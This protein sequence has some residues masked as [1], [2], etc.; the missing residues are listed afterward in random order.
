MW[1]LK[2][3]PYVWT[4]GH[5]QENN[6]RVKNWRYYFDKEINEMRVFFFWILWYKYHVCNKEK[7]NQHDLAPL[8]MGGKKKV[9][10][11]KPWLNPLL[12]IYLVL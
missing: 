9:K 10:T 6:W 7:E 4:H 5:Y 3:N 12:N 11:N 1:Y 2:I 8:V